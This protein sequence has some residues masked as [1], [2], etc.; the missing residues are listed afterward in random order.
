MLP[1]QQQNNT[2]RGLQWLKPEP[3]LSGCP[4][5]KQQLNYIYIVAKFPTVVEQKEQSKKKCCKART[6][7]PPPSHPSYSKQTSSRCPSKSS[8]TSTYKKEKESLSW[9]FRV[10]GAGGRDRSARSKAET[11]T[12]PNT[13]AGQMFLCHKI[14]EKKQLRRCSVTFLRGLSRGVC[15]GAWRYYT[16]VGVRLL[17]AAQPK[18]LDYYDDILYAMLCPEIYRAHYGIGASMKTVFTYPDKSEKERHPCSPL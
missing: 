8:R 5:Q 13:Q 9:L 6:S 15:A 7:L 17:L 14:S 2:V 10:R 1:R 18:T 11:T 12:N 3:R 4:A 16:L